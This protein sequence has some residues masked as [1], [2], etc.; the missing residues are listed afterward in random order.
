MAVTAGFNSHS[1]RNPIHVSGDVRIVAG[2]ITT[3]GTYET[4]G[5]AIT[6]ALFGLDDID[7][8]IVGHSSSAGITGR[9]VQSAGKIL[10]WDEDNTSGIEAELANGATLTSSF[11][12]LVVG[13]LEA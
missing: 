3:S 1:K 12:V 5:F 4:N 8:V 6:A 2:E 10:V 11:P 9:Y 7:A 13:R